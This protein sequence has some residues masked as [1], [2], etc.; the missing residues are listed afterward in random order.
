MII[1][2]IFIDSFINELTNAFIKHSVIL[3]ANFVGFSERRHIIG[4]LFVII[5]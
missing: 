2:G 5:L 4:K 1:N 3:Y